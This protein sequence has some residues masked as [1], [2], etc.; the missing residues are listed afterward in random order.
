MPGAD[1]GEEEE[2]EEDD[3]DEE[4]NLA[5]PFNALIL[6]SSLLPCTAYLVTCESTPMCCHQIETTFGHRSKNDPAALSSIL[7]AYI[8]SFQLIKS[9]DQR[10]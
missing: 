6:P 1:T 8:Q 10:C 7:S 3:D 5:L 2:E 4:A 9:S